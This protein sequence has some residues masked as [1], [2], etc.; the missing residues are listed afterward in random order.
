MFISAIMLN[1]RR[2]KFSPMK[3]NEVLATSERLIFQGKYEK[4]L[5]N[6]ERLENTFLGILIVLR[7]LILRL[8]S[9]DK[10]S[11]SSYLTL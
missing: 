8:V 7:W 3:P 10:T 11:F 2:M 9:S 6:I 1:M 4:A 5:A